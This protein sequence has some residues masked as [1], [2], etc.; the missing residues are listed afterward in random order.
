MAWVQLTM[1]AAYLSACVS[2]IGAWMCVCVCVR[3]RQK[4]EGEGFASWTGRFEPGLR[5]WVVE[6]QDMGSGGS[7][8]YRCSWDKRQAAK[9]REREGGGR[10]LFA[11]VLLLCVE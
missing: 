4:E 9:Q 11:T 2:L 10:V 1:R 5:S 8:L 6:K 3:A 7:F